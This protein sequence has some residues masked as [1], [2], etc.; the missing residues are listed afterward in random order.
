MEQENNY[1]PTRWQ[2]SWI[3]LDSGPFATFARESQYMCY[4]KEYNLNIKPNRTAS[5]FLF[6]P[7]NYQRVE[8]FNT[9][10]HLPNGK[11]LK[12][13]KHIVPINV[14]FLIGLAICIEHGTSMNIKKYNFTC[15]M[16]RCNILLTLSKWSCVHQRKTNCSIQVQI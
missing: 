7:T 16:K 2:F 11:S 5:Y 13:K 15:K 14:P 1:T 3:S 6:G 4:K 8:G 12:I 10:I 9:Q